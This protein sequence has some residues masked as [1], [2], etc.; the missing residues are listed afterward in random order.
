MPWHPN[1]KAMAVYTT[2]SGTEAWKTYDK[3]RSMSAIKPEILE[4]YHS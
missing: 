4:A 2:L 3:L 1:P